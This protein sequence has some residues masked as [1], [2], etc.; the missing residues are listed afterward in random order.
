MQ[1][2]V[3]TRGAGSVALYRDRNR[4][5]C[6]VG[7]QGAESDEGK[8]KLP[9]GTPTEFIPARWRKA[10]VEAEGIISK[11]L[12]EFCLAEQIRHLLRPS[13]EHV[14]GSRLTS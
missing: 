12:W 7:H 5:A 14:P 6:P 1:N 8:R 4:T 3:N 2:Q 11:H 9:P 13:D 10:I